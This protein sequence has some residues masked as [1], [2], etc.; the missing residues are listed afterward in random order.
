MFAIDGPPCSDRNRAS[1]ATST[2]RGTSPG[3]SAHAT[4]K[5]SD[6]AICHM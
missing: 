6:P 2:S 3:V 5:P 1:I 4:T